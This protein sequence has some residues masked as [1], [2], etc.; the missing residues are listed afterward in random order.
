MPFLNKFK[1]FLAF[2]ITVG[3]GLTVI[4]G[5]D[6]AG[7]ETPLDPVDT[8]IVHYDSI[9]VEELES[10]GSFNG[11]NLLDG[12]HCNGSYELRDASLAGGFDST[13]TNFF[14]RSGI[15]DKLDPGKETRWFQVSPNMTQQ[16]F[17]TLSTITQNVGSSLDTLDFTQETTEF[18][19][20]FNYPLTEYP[21][22][23]FWLKGK[24]YA[25]LT[26][27]NNVFGIIRPKISYDTNPGGTFGFSIVFEVRLNKA[28]ENHF[29]HAAH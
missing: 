9:W 16:E 29:Y 21:V 26:G 27:G 4:N 10:A 19:G 6:D 8:N 3:F 12:D 23:C 1:Y 11:I 14:L 15:F 25:N 18:W 17:D 2:V 13:G 5:C 24:K 7:V 22:Y 20:Y 28:G